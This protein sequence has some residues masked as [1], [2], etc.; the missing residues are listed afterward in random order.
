MASIH[1]LLSRIKDTE[2]LREQVQ[3]LQELTKVMDP[4][5][6]TGALNFIKETAEGDPFYEELKPY[7][8]KCLAFLIQKHHLRME[9][10]MDP[11]PAETVPDVASAGA[12]DEPEDDGYVGPQ[13]QD[14]PADS[15][16]CNCQKTITSP[17]YIH[18][19]PIGGNVV[20][21]YVCDDPCQAGLPDV[22]EK[23]EFEAAKRIIRGPQ[24]LIDAMDPEAEEGEGEE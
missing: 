2:D 8:R 13:K 5:I 17:C 22:I 14:A 20:R 10:P 7:A 1:T 19:L 16:C 9:V 4:K 18:D 24:I 12:E 21:L 6:H 23:L 15:T 11:P 3:G